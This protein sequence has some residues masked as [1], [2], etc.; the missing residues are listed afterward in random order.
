[1]ELKL[2][3]RAIDTS[4]DYERFFVLDGRRYSHIID[5][6]TGYPAAGS[7]VSAS[8]VA[9]DSVT[10]DAF[11]TALCVMGRGGFKAIGAV[12]GTD[13]VIVSEEAG[14]LEAHVTDGFMERYHAVR[15]AAL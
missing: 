9:A 10:A 8:V 15:A 5:P 11:A 3:D 13:A 14:K 6:R 12:Q 1:M 4:G 2:S 7:T